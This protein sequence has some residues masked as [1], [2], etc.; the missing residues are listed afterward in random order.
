MAKVLG[1]LTRQPQYDLPLLILARADEKSAPVLSQKEVFH[2][3][4]NFK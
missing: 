2:K 4:R 3:G 1:K